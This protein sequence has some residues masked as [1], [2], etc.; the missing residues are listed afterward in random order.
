[1]LDPTLSLDVG[2]LQRV[3]PKIR[4]FKR[5]LEPGLVELEEALNGAGCARSALVVSRWLDDATSDDEFID[6]TDARIGL[7]R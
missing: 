1:L 2:V 7:L 3:I 4:G 5:D 6:G